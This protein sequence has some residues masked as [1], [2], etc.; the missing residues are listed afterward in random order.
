MAASTAIFR[1]YL[2]LFHSIVF[3]F[4]WM[5][6]KEIGK[7]WQFVSDKLFECSLNKSLECLPVHEINFKFISFDTKEATK[8]EYLHNYFP[9]LLDTSYYCYGKVITHTTQYTKMCTFSLSDNYLQPRKFLTILGMQFDNV[10]RL[11]A[12]Q[13][14]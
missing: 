2:L 14:K 9:M 8:N 3:D 1:K 11:A 6:M 4:Q 12:A 7:K 5:T 13:N 10:L